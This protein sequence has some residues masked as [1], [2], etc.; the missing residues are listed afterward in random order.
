MPSL[1]KGFVAA[2]L[3]RSNASRRMPLQGATPGATGRPFLEV[4][5]T[6]SLLG[7]NRIWQAL[8]NASTVTNE[9]HSVEDFTFGARR[10]YHVIERWTKPGS[11]E[12][13]PGNCGGNP[14][15]SDRHLLRHHQP[16]VTR[17]NRT[18]EDLSFVFTG[19][20]ESSPAICHDPLRLPDGL[21]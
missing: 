1:S 10:F 16:P 7:T 9:I 8:P 18:E 20:V 21:R 15:A 19:C 5:F 13:A 12:A 6:S 14:L 17:R 4:Q 2:L 11:R 3:R